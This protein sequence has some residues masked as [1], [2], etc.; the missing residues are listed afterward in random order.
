MHNINRKSKVIETYCLELI[1][2]VS[3]IL[4]YILALF[5]R[6][7]SVEAI[8]F[9]QIHYYVGVFIL[10]FSLL[11]NIFSDWNRGFFERG[12]WVE[13]IAVVKYNVILSLAIGCMVF[14]MKLGWSFSRLVFGYFIVLNVA[15]T[16]VLHQAFKYYMLH[17]Y[18]KSDSSDKVMI[19]T[20]MRYA[21]A[22]VK[23]I[24]ADKAWNYEITSIALLDQDSSKGTAREITG[25]PVVANRKNLF[26]VAR[27]MPLD[28]V[29][30]YLPHTDIN[31]VK[32]TI[33]D[34]ETMGVICHYNVEIPELNLEGKTAGHFAG[35][36]VMTFSL[37]YLDYRR[38]LLKRMMDI[39]GAI[40]G[41]LITA[42]LTPF[43]ALAIKIESKGPV[44]FSQIR[45]GKNGRR[46]RLWKFRSMYIDAEER[47][48]ELEKQNESDG[49]MFKMEND[50]RITKVGRVIRKLSID[51]LP[52]FFN[53]LIGDM[54]LVGTRPPTVDEFEKYNIQYRRRLCITP[55]LTGMWQVS[56]RSDITKFDEVVELDLK[57]IENWSLWLD[58]KILFQTVGVVLFGK[59]AK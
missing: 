28:E 11:Y 24:L 35:Y 53:V 10:L 15:V 19:V 1:D 17:E 47:K 22:L 3:I 14:L 50:P 36:A 4:A 49:F 52:Q 5:L 39:A 54:S 13:L 2:L 9:L 6:F 18:R 55:G 21:H 48:K 57:Y 26:E 8:S 20:E 37:Q 23:N 29:F 41:L 58:I 46:F 7:G 16:Y 44:F 34:F 27:Q 30:L 33:I 31:L 32:S 43:V 12:K 40:V 59:G 25:I 38:M 42:V 56:G 45:I 51:E